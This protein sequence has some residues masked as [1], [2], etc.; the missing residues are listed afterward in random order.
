MANGTL[1]FSGIHLLPDNWWNDPPPSDPASVWNVWDKNT[2][3]TWGANA[4]NYQGIAIGKSL[5]G[6]GMASDTGPS[7]G[8]AHPHYVGVITMDLNDMPKN[9]AVFLSLEQEIGNGKNVVIPSFKGRFS[10]GTGWGAHVPNWAG[11]Q[12]Y[13]L[14]KIYALGQKASASKIPSGTFWP[15][16]RTDPEKNHPVRK[17]DDLMGIVNNV[18][19]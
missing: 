9:D 8:R 12:K 2:Y 10:L 17:L 14:E 7:R 16:C 13:L 19:T 4:G 1:I 15:D 11:I 6:E 18:L 5:G 3:Y